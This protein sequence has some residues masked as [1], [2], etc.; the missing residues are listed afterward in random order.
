M[1]L[2]AIFALIHLVVQLISSI[3]FSYF[4]T[5]IFDNTLLSHNCNR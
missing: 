5:V 3:T 1:N 2:E 4:V